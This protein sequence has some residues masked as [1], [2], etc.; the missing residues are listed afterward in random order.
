MAVIQATG[1][2]SL[3]AGRRCAQ[4][5]RGQGRTDCPPVPESEKTCSATATFS[6][7]LPVFELGFITVN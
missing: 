2:R 1:V 7:V 3:R 4:V 5:R 6:V